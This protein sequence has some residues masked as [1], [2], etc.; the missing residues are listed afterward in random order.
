MYRLVVFML[1]EI[2]QSE[3]EKYSIVSLI[4]RTYEFIPK[5]NVGAV[6]RNEPILVCT[7][8]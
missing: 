4:G 7:Y 8:E 1:K 6:G 2:S 3:K 5:K